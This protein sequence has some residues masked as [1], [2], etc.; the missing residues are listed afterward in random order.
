M[1]TEDVTKKKNQLVKI[2]FGERDQRL[3]MIGKLV[4]MEDSES[5]E[6]KGMIRFVNQSKLEYFEQDTTRAALTK[7]YVMK[8]FAQ[9]IVM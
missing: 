7:I 3:P 5:L 8:D 1:K 2:I 4:D 6:S 9:I